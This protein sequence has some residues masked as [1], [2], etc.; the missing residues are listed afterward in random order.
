MGQGSSAVAHINEGYGDGR[1]GVQ[2]PLFEVHGFAAD[3]PRHRRRNTHHYVEQT[4]SKLVEVVKNDDYETLLITLDSLSESGTNDLCEQ[5]IKM[6]K[7]D[8]ASYKDEERGWNVFHFAA[9]L[10][11]EH[12]IEKLVEFLKDSDSVNGK[13]TSGQE[14]TALHLAVRCDSDNDALVTLLLQHPQ[15]DI[16]VTDADDWT[17]L[18]HA[19]HRGFYKTVV[20]LQNADFCR[21]NHEGDSP[22]HLAASSHYTTIFS[23]LRE[24]ESFC[25][26]YSKK[27]EFLGLKDQDGNTL[28]HLAVDTAEN[29]LI[30]WCLTFGFSIETENYQGMN[31]M[32]IAAARGDYNIAV[33]ILEVATAEDIDVESFV[34]STST[35]RS[36]PLYMASQSGN[37]KIMEILLENGAQIERKTTDHF[38][39]LLAAIRYIQP[40]PVH[41]LLEQ[42]AD[43]MAKDGQR[44]YNAILW[45]V[46]IQNSEILKVNSLFFFDKLKNL[47]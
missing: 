29:D 41:L 4:S 18:H 25:K 43:V 31:C 16:N 14:F 9:H 6:I 47:I 17:P 20:A 1:L 2:N 26:K 11:S 36:T 28:L 10:Q 45:A 39:P 23:E 12:I 30:E 32:H 19:C 38:T 15:I 5:D 22:L 27:P 8:V 40:G 13:S 46:E 21:I 44:N 37:A 34:N 35:H 3:P 24:C 42:G 7:E 33:K